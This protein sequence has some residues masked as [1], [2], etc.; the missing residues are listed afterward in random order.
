MP[1]LS[2][3]CSGS[4]LGCSASGTLNPHP[5]GVKAELFT[6]DF[7]DPQD[8]AQVK[9][10]ILRAHSVEKQNVSEVCR[11]FGFSRESFYKIRKAFHKRGFSALMPEKRGRKGPKD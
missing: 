9:Y 6:M 8:R 3:R 7:F 11:R 4:S 1:G 10:E 2:H 5:E